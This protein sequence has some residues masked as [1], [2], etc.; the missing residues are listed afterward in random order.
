MKQARD[1]YN[2]MLSVFQRKT[3]CSVKEQT[4]MAVRLYAAAAELES[5]YSYCDWAMNQSFPQTASGE[6]LDK[7][8]A[9]RGLTRK[10][11][12]SAE[13]ILEFS[14]DAQRTEAV[15]VPAG[16]VCTDGGLV[17]FVTVEDG[18]I[19]AGESI[20]RVAAKAESV[21]ESGNA[22]AYTVTRMPIAPVGISAC[23]NPQAF[24]GGAEEETDDALRTRV[25]QSFSRLPNG[26]NAAFYEQKALADPDVAGVQVLP[27]ARGI[28]TVDVVISAMGGVPDADTIQRVQ[29][30]IQAVR[31]ICVDV[32]VRAP[33]VQAL[34]VSAVVWPADGVSGE[35]ACA[36][37]ENAV[38]GF[39]T[40]GLLGKAVYPAQL[41][42]VIY[43][44]GKVRNY[45][46]TAPAADVPAQDGVLP[47]LGELRV[48]EGD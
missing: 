38:R 2:E 30:D 17:R 7:H 9:L 14:L 3:G 42:D 40:G 44:T 41:A 27:R 31:E 20:C 22:A 4:D 45:V 25:L 39:F 24:T 32:S 43:A 12:R 48:T 15:S 46:I 23:T 11:A 29:A 6:H 35:E 28:G 36:A 47:V 37:A 26:A 13:G 21:G 34:D 1:I 10:Q 16:T 5:L 8:A 18:V 33:Q 19:P